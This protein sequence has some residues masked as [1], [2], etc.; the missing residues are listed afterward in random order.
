MWVA[1]RCR[2]EVLPTGSREM[3]T[4]VTTSWNLAKAQDERVWKQF[5]C[6]KHPQKRTQLS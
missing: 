4:Q 2:N 5:Y 6:P 3:E 1:F